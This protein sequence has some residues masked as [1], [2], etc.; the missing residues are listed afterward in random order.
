MQF[1]RKKYLYGHLSKMKINNFLIQPTLLAGLILKLFL[2]FFILPI[3]AYDWYVPFIT[4][5]NENLSFD[6]W[7]NW[8]A[9]G[10]SAGAFPYG[11]IMYLV[12]SPFFYLFSLLNINLIY[13]YMFSLLFVDFL[14]LVILSRLYPG[15]DKLL[16]IL[17]WLSPITIIATYIYGFND[18]IPVLLL[19]Q[20]ILFIK[21]RFFLASGITLML[22]VSAKLSMILVLPF[23]ILYLY[24]NKQLRSKLFLFLLGVFVSGSLIFLPILLFSSALS[25]I[26]YTPEISKIFNM[27]INFGSTL[28]IYLIPLIYVVITYF[29]WRVRRF[30]IDIFFSITGLIF[31]TIAILSPLAPGWFIWFIPV[32]SVYQA[33]SGRISIIVFSFFSLIYLFLTVLNYPIFLNSNVFFDFYIIFK[34]WNIELLNTILNTLL[35]SIGII[36]W[37]RMLRELILENKFFIGSRN[38]FLIGISGDSGSG[39]DTLSSLIVKLFG[40]S[41]VAQISGDNYHLWDRNKPMWKVMTPLNPMANDLDRFNS[42]LLSLKNGKSINSKFYDHQQ[43]KVTKIN[44]IISNDFIVASGLHILSMPSSRSNYNLSIF[45]DMDE[46]LRTFY[47]LKRD[48]QDRNIKKSKVMSNLIKRKNDS[49][50]FIK[51]QIQFA[52]LIFSLAPVDPNSLSMDYLEDNPKVKLVVCSRLGGNGR[53]LVRILV[54]I[55]GLNITFDDYNDL[56]KLSF[57]IEGD[58]ASDDIRMAVKRL[59]PDIEEFLDFDANYMEGSLGLMQLIVLYFIDQNLSTRNIN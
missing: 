1:V 11:Y 47:K 38:P 31:L 32:V 7:G 23:F 44:H 56:S 43:G 6:I 51:P 54:G 17:Y 41:S 35:F 59:C 13:A 49:D 58:I 42:D 39:K 19:L 37:I 45:L 28:G 8:E 34:E 48:V 46:N 15:Y 57:T 53:E 30:N 55:C 26:F 14:V 40:A 36:I 18:L 12:F 16:T 50:I 24:N 9:S 10:G 33:I 27:S 3:A 25:M 29:V 21:K 5:T 4:F 20:S 22:S 52:N 2:I